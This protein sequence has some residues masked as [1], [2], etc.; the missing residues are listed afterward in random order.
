MPPTPA[1]LDCLVDAAE[2][3]EASGTG[4]VTEVRIGSGSRAYNVVVARADEDTWDEAAAPLS[5]DVAEDPV[6]A[7]GV[8][9]GD[10]PWAA[11]VAALTALPVP[12]YTEA[13]GGPQTAA[14]DFELT[15]SAGPVD[16]FW[17]DDMGPRYIL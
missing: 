1:A 7:S 2:S 11:S 17:T 9:D 10:D 3:M 15:A 6:E 14:E 5:G 8:L 16:P 12:A 4:R 13:A